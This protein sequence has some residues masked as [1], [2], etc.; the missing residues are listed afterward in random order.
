MSFQINKILFI[1]VLCIVGSNAQSQH[2]YDTLFNYDSKIKLIKTEDFDD[3][4]LEVFKH[5]KDSTGWLTESEV[6]D[7]E[8]L[9]SSELLLWTTYNGNEFE[10]PII[11]I[12]GYSGNF[13][14]YK[15][16]VLIYCYG[17]ICNTDEKTQYFKT[18]FIKVDKP[19][20]GSEFVL[21]IHI[22]GRLDLSGFTSLY[23]G[24]SNFLADKVVQENRSAFRSGLLPLIIGILM[25]IAGIFALIAFFLRFRSK[26][27]LLFWFFVFAASQGYLFVLEYV[28]MLLNISPPVFFSTYIIINNFVPI[29]ILGIVQ[30]ISGDKRNNMIIVMMIL[31]SVYAPF[32]IVFLEYSFYDF[33]YWVLVII[34]TALVIFLIFRSGIYKKPEMLFPA[35]SLFI[36]AILVIIEFFE[37][38]G[39]IKTGI[40]SVS[41]YGML[42]LVLSFAYYIERSQYKARKKNK[43]YELESQKTKMK[44]LSLENEGVIA[45]YEALKNQ[46]DPHFLFNSLNS[47]SSLIR[48]DDKKAIQFIEE[49]A[50]IYRYVL[51]A[52]GKTVV[53][54]GEE[55]KFIN[56]YLFLQKLRYGDNLRVTSKIPDKMLDFYVVPL[57]IQILVENAIK[58]NEI[59]D[60]HPLNIEIGLENDYIEI[61]NSF[62]E[63]NFKPI[64]NGIGLNNLKAR[65]ALLT[66]KKAE[67]KVFENKY[68]AR[69]PI[70]KTEDI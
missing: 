61:V 1:V 8:F 29:G 62:K 48:S 13:Q 37:V 49:F 68:I 45:Q 67:F 52:N 58:H 5:I 24:E 38:L 23:I 33:L 39:N 36:I 57:S 15:D 2:L 54:I 41:S 55:L 50:D 18:H 46:V 53:K 21:R 35:I 43:E 44:L 3:V 4:E 65:Y 31:H 20:K 19:C 69:I 64:S 14:L 60:F 42:L 47:L 7:K 11:V 32:N 16:D 51:D 10:N 30:R 59:S 12:N 34:D 17:D 6:S 9:N 40:E 63:L 28:Y 66:D 27:W 70:L 26:E 22:G 56:S 25:M